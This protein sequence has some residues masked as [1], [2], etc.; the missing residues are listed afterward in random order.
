[1]HT[2]L[3]RYCVEFFLRTINKTLNGIVFI[4]TW[5]SNLCI[6]D[7]YVK[8]VQGG[9]SDISVLPTNAEYFSYT[10]YYVHVLKN[11]EMFLFCRLRW[12]GPLSTAW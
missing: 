11:G 5:F 6:S 3:L 4:D 10:H 1:M 8:K 2:D 12:C 9:V 7:I